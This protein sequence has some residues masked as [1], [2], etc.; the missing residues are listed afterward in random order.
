M[1]AGSGPWFLLD[2]S[3][4]ALRRKPADY[5]GL[6][7]LSSA[8]ACQPIQI[9]LQDANQAG[10]VDLA[11]PDWLRRLNGILV[12]IQINMDSG[13]VFHADLRVGR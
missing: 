5:Y 8:S 3:C 9:A 13:I 7:V 2:A 1:P 11:Q 10:A 4:S 12:D 6:R